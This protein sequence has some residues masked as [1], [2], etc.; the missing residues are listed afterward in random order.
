MKTLKSISLSLV[1][2]V[3][4]FWFIGCE[5]D[6]P[7]VP[8][9]PVVT[10]VTCGT[11]TPTAL[12]QGVAY[13]GSISISYT[14][15]NGGPY[16]ALSFS[17]NGLTATAGA[18]NLAT[19]N[20]SITL[21]VTGNTTTVGPN[22]INVSLGGQTCSFNFT[23]AAPTAT[24]PTSATIT[25][26]ASNASCVSSNNSVNFTWTAGQNTTTYGIFIRN[27]LT[28]Q[29]VYSTSGL[30]GTSYVVPVGG[31]S[32]VSL[33]TPYRWWLVSSNTGSSTTAFSNDTTNSRFYL[34]GT[35]T[36]SNIPFPAE[37]TGPANN[38]R[39]ASPFTFSWTGSSTDNNIVSYEFWVSVGGSSSK[40]NT[41]PTTSTT[42]TYNYTFTNASGT[43]VKWWIVTNDRN[44]NS[45]SSDTRT[46]TVN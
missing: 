11:L 45:S 14:G 43:Q 29:L 41:I 22:T 7:T 24:T 18:G 42:G 34:A 9:T 19:G 40:I 8:T 12:T 16:P 38:Q 17:A 37:L 5:P 4:T 35:A 44:G 1:A 30:T 32:T 13:T 10:T 2:F 21:A 6:K 26:P 3:C 15:G 31:N 23:V 39:I 46:F 28:K 36:T 27:L 25:Y 20:G 33:A